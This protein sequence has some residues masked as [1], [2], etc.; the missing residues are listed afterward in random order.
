MVAGSG[1]DLV[2]L[3]AGLGV[4]GLYWGPVH[5]TL[6]KHVRVVAYERAGFGGSDSAPGESRDL[7]YLA[8]DLASVVNAF[9]HKRLV[10]VGHSWGAP[11]I[12]TFA[13]IRA[14]SDST[15]VGLVLVDQSDEHAADLYTSRLAR[16]SDAM[17][18]ALFVPLARA[19][20]L[21]PLMKTQLAGLPAEILRA[22]LAASSTV[23]A[24][25]AT[26]QENTHVA[27]DLLRL[28]SDPPVLRSAQLRVISGQQHSRIDRK[29]RARLVDAHQQTARE[30]SGAQFVAAERSGHMV[31]VTEP[32]LI[33]KH[34]LALL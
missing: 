6:A 10:L 11:I 28:R 12:R 8:A 21:A 16:W 14:G 32:E 5:A 2:V 29:I 30:H 26:S 15:L 25:R 19:R 20:L 24:A 1:D 27:E 17:Q 22:A 7:A 23:D 4:S 18:N 33:A 9:P 31:P 3:E 13:A 34:A